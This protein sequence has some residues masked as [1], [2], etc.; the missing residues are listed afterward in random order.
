MRII[1]G[2][3]RSRTLVAPKGGD[4][5]PT[6]DRTRE[7]L[8]NILQPMLFDAHVLDL[9]AGSGALALEALSRG[10]KNAVVV[11]CAS[12]AQA[13]IQKNIEA[14]RYS[15]CAKLMKMTDERALDVLKKAGKC[16][17]II[18]LDPPYRV[19]VSGVLE[20]IATKGLLTDAGRVIVEHDKKTPPKPPD[21]LKVYDVRDYRGT[22]ITFLRRA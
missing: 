10:A 15:E 8:F 18:F 22:T 20:S 12:A 21:L 4:T 5:R 9:Y 11:D 14:L 1:G 6:L 7:S 19:D 13:A 3:H 2:E 17:D 16:F